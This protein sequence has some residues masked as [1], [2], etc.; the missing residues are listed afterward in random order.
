MRGLFK[1]LCGCTASAQADLHSATLFS[2][3]PLAAVTPIALAYT[4][5][6]LGDPLSALGRLDQASKEDP[7]SGDVHY[8]RGL[9]LLNDLEEFAAAVEAFRSCIA[10][11]KDT[12]K[13]GGLREEFI[14]KSATAH[15]GVGLY[16]GG[17][18][19][20]S[21]EIFRDAE[22]DFP[23]SGEVLMYQ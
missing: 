10:I 1:L 3:N 8:H 16:R 23:G 7:Q 12:E 4:Y 15:L 18:V 13:T 9:L 21:F 14:L 5:L 2:S 11:L 22:R 19:V 6:T 20:R 17:E